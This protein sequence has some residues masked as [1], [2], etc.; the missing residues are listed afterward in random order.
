MLRE[1]VGALD[2]HHLGEVPVVDPVLAEVGDLH[3]H[4]PPPVGEGVEEGI[5]REFPDKLRLVIGVDGGELGLDQA[6][7]AALLARLPDRKPLVFQHPVA[8]PGEVDGDQHLVGD[9]GGGRK[10]ADLK[11]A[12]LLEQVFLLDVAEDED[13]PAFVLPKLLDLRGGELHHVVGAAAGQTAQPPGDLLFSLPEQPEHRLAGKAPVE[14]LKVVG[15]QR[16][17]GVSAVFR[18]EIPPLGDAGPHRVPL[19]V[20]IVVG[21]QVGDDALVEDGDEALRVH[22]LNLP[23]PLLLLEVLP[24][25]SGGHHDGGDAVVPD[26][27]VGGDVDGALQQGIVTDKMARRA[28]PQPVERTVGANLGPD[29]VA[30]CPERGPPA[31]GVPAAEIEVEQPVGRLF[32]DVYAGF[33]QRVQ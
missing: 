6:F 26:D 18:A 21:G 9:L 4:D 13:A 2:P 14:E 29:L 23:Q 20:D 17:L 15:M 3:R 5:A 8:V 22:P 19:A 7:K 10:L 12:L 28:V 30:F 27:P 16:F 1:S 33:G 32:N 31:P 25:G 24:V 11:A